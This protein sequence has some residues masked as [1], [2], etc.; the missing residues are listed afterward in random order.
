MKR[1]FASK[2]FACAIIA[3]LLPGTGCQKIYDYVRLPQNGNATVTDCRINR[4]DGISAGDTVHYQFTYNAHGD[5]VS[6]IN[7]RTGTGNPNMYFSYDPQHRLIENVGRYTNNGYE[8]WHRYGY[9]ILHQIAADTSFTF[10]A[11]G[12]DG[13]PIEEG[14]VYKTFI[15]YQYDLQNR[16]V[17]ETDSTFFYGSFAW[18]DQH[19]YA[20]DNNGNLATGYPAG[21][22]SKLSILRTHTIWM[23]LSRNYSVNNR[24]T[25]D[26]YNEHGLPLRFYDQ[27]FTIGRVVPLTSGHAVVSYVCK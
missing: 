9:N 14:A 17:A 2:L 21:Y 4:V 13:K 22:D 20:Y 15:R 25:A 10:G 27:Y 18:V 5:P 6:I 11:I 24:F 23:F 7:S 12:P 19:S 3:S 1:G 8:Q 16:I 26:T